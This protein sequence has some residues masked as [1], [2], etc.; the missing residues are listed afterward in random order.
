MRMDASDAQLLHR[1]LRENSEAAFADLVRRHFDLVYS[2]ATR[3][4]AGDAE[5]ARDV[6]Q[7]VFA[8]LARK[9]KSLADRSSLTGWL[10]TSTHFA[11]AKMVRGEQRRRVREQK[12][13]AMQ[14]T[15]SSTEPSWEQ[16]RPTIDEAMHELTEQERDAVLLRFF[17]GCEFRVVG[18]ALGVSEEA[19][20]KR[21]DR[22]LEKLRAI[23]V[24]HGLTSTS[25]SL[26]VALSSNAVS[27]APAGLAISIGGAALATVAAAS[28]LPAIVNAMT[29]SKSIV[30]GVSALVLAGVVTPVLLQQRAIQRLRADNFRAQTEL[31]SLRETRVNGDGVSQTEVDAAELERLRGEHRELLRLRGEVALL[32]QQAQAAAPKGSIPDATALIQQ[33]AQGQPAPFA[34]LTKEAIPSRYRFI[35]TDQQGR[36]LKDAVVTLHADGSFTNP[37]GERGGAY[38]WTLNP[39]GLMLAWRTG[40]MLFNKVAAPGVYV[41]AKENNQTVRIEK[42]GPP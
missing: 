29:M 23:L 42:I 9:A 25:A 31:A 34:D 17:E 32:R 7:T 10:Y 4:V 1:Y 15:T 13:V 18:E 21:V 28:P 20:R 5:L 38:K 40:I 19:A 35:E 39:Q 41:A 8:D 22:A 16:I 3:Q 30:A 12:A 26:A 2:A 36:V 33:D 27:V 11:A 37:D 24:Q 14:E 6:A